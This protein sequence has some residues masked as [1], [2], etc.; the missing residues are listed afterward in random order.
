MRIRIVRALEMFDYHGL[1][2]HDV[3]YQ[4]FVVYTKHDRDTKDTAITN[5]GIRHRHNINVVFI[6]LILCLVMIM[7][8]V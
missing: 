7:S 8:M 3:R 5:N 6:Y 2:V 1:Y 4:R